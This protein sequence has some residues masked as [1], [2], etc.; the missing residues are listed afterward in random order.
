MQEELSRIGFAIVLTIFSAKAAAEVDDNAWTAI[1]KWN[2]RNHDANKNRTWENRA[3]LFA[4]FVAEV[5][6]AGST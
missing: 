6:E 1:C 4:R 2:S 3:A 5:K